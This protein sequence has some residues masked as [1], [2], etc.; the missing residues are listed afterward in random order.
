M[1]SKQKKTIELLTKAI[2]N[3]DFLGKYKD[4]Y[5][6]KEYKVT[7]Y[8]E[9]GYVELYCVSGLKNDEG[10]MASIFCRRTRQIFI[11]K[12]GGLRCYD[13]TKKNN[14]GAVLRN[15]TDVVIFGYRAY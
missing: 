8:E 13:N 2:E 1:T 14:K 6:F 5:E 12:N 10:T 9:F 4:D 3:N 15:W 11:G 7:E